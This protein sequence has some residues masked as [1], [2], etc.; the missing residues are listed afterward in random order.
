MLIEEFEKNGNP[1]QKCSF[2]GENDPSGM[3]MGKDVIFCCKPCAT[4]YLPQLMADT[5]VG[6]TSEK[7][8]KD[9]GHLPVEVTK[10]NKILRRY[11]GAFSTALIRKFRHNKNA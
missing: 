6:G 7:I 2:C 11:H 10:E 4:D 3:W 9:S 5:I 1:I 8:I